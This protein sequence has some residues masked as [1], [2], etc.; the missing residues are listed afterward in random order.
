[1][2]GWRLVVVIATIAGLAAGCSSATTMASPPATTAA[3]SQGPP[4]ARVDVLPNGL[5]LV[6]QDHRAA[7]IVA[8][9]L[10]VAT[11]VRYESPETLGHAHFQEHMLF[12]GTETFGPGYIDRT[13]EG[14][15]GRS[16]AFTTFDYT[17]FQVLVPSEATRTAIQ[18]L[19]DMAFRSKFDPKEVDAERQVIFEESRI[20]TDNPRTA[21]IRQLHGLVFGDH[22]YG[23][24]VLGTP[25]TMSAATQENLKAFNRRY[26]TPENMV[27]VVAGP[28][29]AGAVRAMVDAT[30]GAR[31]RTSYTPPPVPPLTPIKA[32]V[33]RTVERPEQQA[34]LILGWQ[35]PS[36]ADPD[37]LALDL[38]ATIL[39]G[40]E[41]SRLA[42]TL[43]D[44][45]RIVSRIAVNNSTLR[46]T[47]IVYVQ[48]QLEAG[49]VEKV[50][51]RILE[52]ITRLQQ[53]GP[54]EE[55]RE[56]AV[57]KAESEH[58]LSYETSDGVASA[59]G[60]AMT[61][62]KLEDEVRY[63]ER[64]RTIT[65]EQ[66]RDAARKYLPVTAYALIAFVPARTR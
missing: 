55:E 52:E 28:V 56:L 27:L 5:T 29:E 48:A 20:E 8:V 16:N 9:H 40:S 1:M 4:P 34:Y 31:P 39:G 50:E 57:T 32:I 17:T 33:R 54:T 22:P 49:D 37:S 30:L 26:Y 15:G 65:R 7:D 42:R 2:I 45:E 21:I 25:A 11:G 63:I 24:P 18:L 23:R 46:L 41:S 44:D 35:A 51:R 3:T 64:L 6:V 66:I 43:R 58:A 60:T 59:Y 38:V 19:D 53:E 36:L 61:T 47:G 12:K 14:T 62:A 13:V 10:W